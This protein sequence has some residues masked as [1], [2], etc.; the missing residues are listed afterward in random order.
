MLFFFW[1]IMPEETYHIIYVGSV[2]SRCLDRI[3]C[4]CVR[5]P[6]TLSPRRSALRNCHKAAVRR[7]ERAFLI[8]SSEC[9]QCADLPL[10]FG[11]KR[12][13]VLVKLVV[14]RIKLY[15]LANR[16]LVLNGKFWIKSKLIK[17]N[18][19]E[20]HLK[21]RLTNN[22]HHWYPADHLRRSGRAV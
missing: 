10:L 11:R 22:M 7:Q 6:A 4:R 17:Q 20:T 3:P 15:W 14:L 2:R 19:S 16:W 5:Q 8:Q 13:M 9:I 1:K 21:I 18:R 12:K